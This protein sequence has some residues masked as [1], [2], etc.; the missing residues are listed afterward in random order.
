MS[1]GWT[2]QDS[3]VSM[4]V[5]VQGE[6]ENTDRDPTQLLRAE[7]RGVEGQFVLERNWEMNQNWIGKVE[8]SSMLKIMHFRFI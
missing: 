2:V 8:F 5:A 3:S 1:C 7:Q 4:W 6:E